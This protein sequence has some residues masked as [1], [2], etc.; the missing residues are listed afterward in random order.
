MRT[1]FEMPRALAAV[2]ILVVAVV[3][4]A[5]FAWRRR[6]ARLA[7][8]AAE[9]LV[10]RLVPPGAARVPRTRVVLLGLAA[11]FAGLA[12]A[13]PRWGL[14]SSVVRTSG[15]D[16]VVALDASLSML[17]TDEK[18]SRLEQMKA[19]TRRLLAAS[20]G[21]RVG[22]IAFA[23]RSYILTP[24]TVDAGALELFLDNL[25]PSIVGQAGSSLART[26]RQGT[27]LLLSTRSGSDRALVIIS[28]GEAF[29]PVDDVRA[30]AKRAAEAGVTV[31]TIGVGT[32]AGSTIP[33]R[34]ANGVSLKRDEDGAIVVTRYHPEMLQAAATEDGIFIPA[35]A[36]DKAA[37]ARHALD[38]LRQVQRV[39]RTAEN[40]QP[41]YQLFVLPALVCVLLDTMLAE[42]RGRR[43]SSVI[44]ASM[45]AALLACL[46]MPRAAYADPGRDGDRLF[47]DGRYADA[48]AAYRSAIGEGERSARLL[49]NYGTALLA[50]GQRE[51]AMEALR[52]SAQST[53][54]NLRYR[55]LFNLGLAH[56]ERARAAHA[57]SAGE[58]FAAA[59]EAYKQ[60]LRLRPDALDAKWNYELSLR[61]PH[62]GGGGGG[63]GTPQSASPS[64]TAPPAPRPAPQPQSGLGERQAEQILNSAAREEQEVQ[65]KQQRA[66]HPV[67]PPGGKDW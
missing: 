65:E 47:R 67:R 9:P 11:L 50:A 2:P 36:T 8:L 17:A 7:R 12:F 66:N 29:E 38:R 16:I 21:D 26:I 14:E 5:L 59:R 62:G 37:R 31:I 55:A 52:E 53:D 30:A 39:S 35:T 48:A 46:V 1:L 41:R 24:L 60:A 10:A 57:D 22:L 43:R 33:V 28:D 49:Y 40:R 54:V 20:T 23:G 15:A 42:R 64:T 32:S 63:G 25:D 56:L 51:A 18:P 58:D 44:A 13:G 45:A 3:A 19:E 6:R 4:L 61:A 34:T 27:D